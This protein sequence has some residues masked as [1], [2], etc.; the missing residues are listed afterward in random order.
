ML[1][2][3]FEVFAYDWLVVIKNALTNN[4]TTIINDPQKLQDFYTEHKDNVWIGYNSRHYDQFIL[5]AI[6]AGLSP[7]KMNAHI[8][9]EKKHGSQYSSLIRSIQLYNYDV[10]NSFHGLKQLEG[11]MGESIKETSVPFDIKRKLTDRE[12]EEVVQYCRHDVEQTQKVF[13]ATAQEFESQ[14]ALL[15]AFKL[16][17]EKIS[18]TKAQLSA[19]ILGAKAKPHDDEFDLIIP[20]TI[21]LDR[22]KWIMEWYKNPVNLRYDSKIET[23][24]AGVPHVFAWGGLHGAI[25]NYI[26]RERGVY[27]SSDVASY[28]PSLMIEYGFASRNIKDPNKYKE[29]YEE[30]LRL[31]ALKDPKQA[32]Y[33]IVLNATYGSM[34]DK[35]NALY[36]PLMANNVC[37]SG[38][39]MLLDLIEK[40]ENKLGNKAQLIQSNTDGIMF[41]LDSED[42][43]DQYIEICN[44]WSN[45]TRMGLEHDRYVF[46][47]QKDVNNY[48]IVDDQG[49]YKSKGAYV[50]K[51]NK[52]DYDLP[53]VNKALVYN[54]IH[55][56]PVEQTINE[57]NDL[58]E[59]QKIVKVSSKY[60]Y[61]TYGNE[62]LHERVLRVFASRSMSD[63]GVFKVKKATDGNAYRVEKIANTPE[64]CFI[65]NENIVGAKVPRKLDKKYYI[66]VANKRIRDF[67]G[68]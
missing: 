1:F 31:K 40:V 24:I 68:V 46:V 66:D 47:A 8:I 57:C 67:K 26:S 59:F 64:R 13:E 36:D 25:P 56:V 29:I 11:F 10:M 52:L 58:I 49:K 34:K 45:R 32:P 6:V 63:E 53:I 17:L 16:P 44:E 7:Q 12:I 5:K 27:I 41:R 48:I 21:K 42:L 65:V 19:T 38:Q 35:Y 55:G 60:L 14:I 20:D 4:V 39:L 61:G 3:D 15:K 9:E 33:K 28:Y 37:V 2:Y 50:K 23:N 43:M 30:R 51:L 54:L 22:Y 62:K 18:K